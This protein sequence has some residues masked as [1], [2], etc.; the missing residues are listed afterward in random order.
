M[1]LLLVSVVLTLVAPLRA[2][3]AQRIGGPPNIVFVLTDDQRW[4]MTGHSGNPLIQTPNLDLLASQ[5]MLLTNFYT[6]A[7]L[8]SPSRA[9]IISGLY[10]HQVGNGI[11]NNA[12]WTDV[13]DSVPTMA[14]HL[15]DAGYTTCYVGKTHMG[16]DPRTWG[17][18]DTPLWLRKAASEHDSPRLIANGREKRFKDQ[19]ITSLFVRASI[20]F[21]TKRGTNGNPFF[22]FLSTTTPHGPDCPSCQVTYPYALADIQANLPP[23]LPPGDPLVL[24]AWEDYYSKITQLDNEMGKLMDALDVNGLASN[25]YFVFTS[26]HGLTM[27]QFEAPAKGTWYDESV[28]VPCIVRGPG[29]APGSVFTGP[30]VSVDFLPTFLEIAGVSI[31]ANLEGASLLPALTGSTPLRTMA[32]SEVDGAQHDHWHMVRSFSGTSTGYKYVFQ[33]NTGDEYLYNLNTDPFE[34]HNLVATGPPPGV[35]S[36][37]VQNYFDWLIATP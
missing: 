12:P 35:L 14:S 23:G 22:L 26:D 29:I 13:A 25:T 32:Y 11:L 31:P 3:E 6:A 10:P 19:N 15:N 9:S 28:K 37:M 16:G 7:P 21:I 33:V 18:Q 34:Q 20:D 1:I 27:S 17:F 8:C 30:G 36:Q 2:D 24:F 4:D 5:G